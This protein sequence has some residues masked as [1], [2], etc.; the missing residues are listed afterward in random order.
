MKTRGFGLVELLVVMTVTMTLG[1]L[2]ATYVNGFARTASIQRDLGDLDQNASI[3]ASL[4]RRDLGLAGYRGD[5]AGGPNDARAVAWLADHWNRLRL[6]GKPVATLDAAAGADGDVLVTRAVSGVV[7]TATGARFTLREVS[8]AL[9]GDRRV[10]RRRESTLRTGEVPF[11]GGGTVDLSLDSG[12]W[13]VVA[14]GVEGFDVFFRGS[15]AWTQSPKPSS[16]LAGVYVLQRPPNA[17]ARPCRDRPAPKLPDHAVALG[18]T[19]RQACRDRS[20]QR[21]LYIALPNPQS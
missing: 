12:A 17:R 6:G 15:D 18:V 4:L 10:L 9:D 5:G 19:K 11:T 21:L 20:T 16:T 8:W 14:E 2:F 7:A 1:L 13:V 3:V